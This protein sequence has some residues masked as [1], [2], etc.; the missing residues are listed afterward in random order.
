MMS[1]IKPTKS[2]KKEKSRANNEPKGGKQWKSGDWTLRAFLDPRGAV[3][4]F[5]DV[6]EVKKGGRLEDLL[7]DPNQVMYFDL[8][9][10][11]FEPEQKRN[12]MKSH[13]RDH[14]I[15]GKELS[16]YIDQLLTN[17]NQTMVQLARS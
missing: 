4:S 8:E 5:R 15:P 13:E 6:E 16:Y 17:F 2:L 12:L 11:G 7:P 14:R 9:R 10:Y 3:K 1:S